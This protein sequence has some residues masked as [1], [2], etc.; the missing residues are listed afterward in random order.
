MFRKK[1]ELE[2]HEDD[3]FSNLLEIFS[4]AKITWNLR[5]KRCSSG[6]FL[7][8]QR[9]PS[10]WRQARSIGFYKPIVN[11]GWNSVV[12]ELQEHSYCRAFGL[13]ARAS[14]T[15]RASRLCRS[16]PRG[17]RSVNPECLDWHRRLQFVSK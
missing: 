8:F 7:R 3:L 17:L 12:D 4:R 13:L 9:G 14:F 2:Q 1:N 10:L 11:D 6:R 15:L 5:S 16:R